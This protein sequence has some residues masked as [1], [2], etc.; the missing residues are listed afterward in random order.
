VPLLTFDV[1]A[2]TEG[3]ITEFAVMPSL[4]ANDKIR[5]AVFVEMIPMC[6]SMQIKMIL[7]KMLGTF[8]E[9]AKRCGDVYSLAFYES[10]K[11]DLELVSNIQLGDNG[12][13][14]WTV[15]ARFYPDEKDTDE[16]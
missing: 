1:A 16:E 13:D 10:L 12:S 11:E 15:K 3:H 8:E 14:E 4:S 7:L 2:V 6:T 9:S 5:I